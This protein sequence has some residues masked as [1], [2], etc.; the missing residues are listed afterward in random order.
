MMALAGGWLL[1]RVI[2]CKLADEDKQTKTQSKTETV[3]A[4]EESKDRNSMMQKKK[5]HRTEDEEK[6][7][8][9][10]FENINIEKIIIIYV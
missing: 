7:C 2:F 4:D 6:V 10:C 5:E 9:D 1:F 3:T 8:V